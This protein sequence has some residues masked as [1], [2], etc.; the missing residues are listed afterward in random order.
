MCER[1]RDDWWIVASEQKSL[2][3]CTTRKLIKIYATLYGEQ[4]NVQT[5]QLK[6]CVE[7]MLIRKLFEMI[8]NGA[9]M[10]LG[11]V[12]ISL[13]LILIHGGKIGRTYYASVRLRVINANMDNIVPCAVRHCHL[14]RKKNKIRNDEHRTRAFSCSIHMNVFI[15][16]RMDWAVATCIFLLFFFFNFLRLFTIPPALCLFDDDVFGV[17]FFSARPFFSFVLQATLI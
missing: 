8:L 1:Y 17:F 5:V 11:V 7:S 4:Q 16:H 12:K 10:I 9:M 15:C 13:D 3:V 6:N 2:S 14:L